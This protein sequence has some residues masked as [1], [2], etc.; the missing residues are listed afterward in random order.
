MHII[1]PKEIFFDEKN[2][3]L[4]WSAFTDQMIGGLSRGN[5]KQHEEHL[6]FSGNVR[7]VSDQAWA[8]MRSRSQAHNLSDYKFIELKIK[9][10]GQPY[11]LQMEFEDAWQK[12]K[13]GIEIDIVK[14][15]WKTMHLEMADFKTYN[16]RE[17]F[18]NK[19]PKLTKVLPLIKRYNIMASSKYQIDFNFQIE[20]L[21]FH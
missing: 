16:N 13:L 12:D 11:H 19:K 6:E 21:K 18:L 7:P 3:N 5:I 2:R 20:Y 15:Q 4:E 14:N 1:T 10:D 17:G 9:T 8:G